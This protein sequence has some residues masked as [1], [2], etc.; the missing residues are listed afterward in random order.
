MPI[1]ARG[2]ADPVR[3]MYAAKTGTKRRQVRV[4]KAIE[5]WTTRAYLCFAR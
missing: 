4:T 1:D 3:A 5:S 2:R